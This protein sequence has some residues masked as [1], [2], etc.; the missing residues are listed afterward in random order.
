MASVIFTYEG[1]PLKV[2]CLKEDKMK[3]ICNKYISKININMN[4]LYF[5]YGGNQINLELTFNQQANSIDK[6]RN[7]MNILVY[8]KEEERLKCSKCGEIINLDI[9]DN[10]IKNNQNDLLKGLKSQ[11]ENIINLCDINEIKIQI[12]IIKIVLDN[13]IKENEKNIN[14]IKNIINNYNKK[15]ENIIKG[16]LYIKQKELNNKIV[17]FN[18]D[19]KDKIDV[20]LNNKKIN[21]INDNNKWLVDYHFKN[22]ESIHLKFI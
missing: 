4:S 14:N 12:K 1:L 20:F 7:E 18:S 9:F 2:Q 13:I 15:K 8:R 19:I 22:E 17:L 10:I 6:E 16:E 11:L 3:D 5:L 21:M